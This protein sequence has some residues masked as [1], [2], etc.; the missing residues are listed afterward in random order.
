MNK[1]QIG[2]FSSLIIILIVVILLIT[3]SPI[4]TV[5]LY[6]GSSIPL[7]TFIT[8]SG[9]VSLPLCIFWGI[10]NLR[11]PKNDFNKYLGLTLKVLLLTALLWVPISYLLAGNLS[12]SFTEKDTFQGGQLAMTW[13][14]RISYATAIGPILLLIIYWIS[15]LSKKE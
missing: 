11:N 4:L 2:F 9:L 13:F 8:W 10:N 1:Q 14:W 7:G 3:G 5:P 15:L 6:K 12:F